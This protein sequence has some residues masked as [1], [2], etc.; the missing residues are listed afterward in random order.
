MMNALASSPPS[1]IAAV[2]ALLMPLLAFGIIIVV[3]RSRH[4]LSA[5]LSI[6]AI[7]FSAVMAISLLLL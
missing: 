6:G 2:A 1:L 7:G 3:T 5:A 4:G